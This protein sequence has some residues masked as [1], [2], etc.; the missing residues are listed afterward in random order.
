MSRE[1][2]RALRFYTEVLGLDHLHYGLW[3]PDEELTLANM[4][5]A[6]LRYED[7]LIGKLPAGA[8]S[9][10]DVGCG[11][12]AMTRRMLA[13]GLEVEGLSPDETQKDTFTR[14]LSVPFH[15]SRFEDFD[16]NRRYD[17]LVMSESCQYIPMEPLMEKVKARLN[18]GGHLVICDYFVL[19]NAQGIMAKSGH[20]YDRFKTLAERSGLQLVE[21]VDVTEGAARTLDLA[22][23]MAKRGLL[24]GDILTEKVRLKHPFITRVVFRLFR[25]KW[26]KINAERILIDSSAFKANKKYVYLKYRYAG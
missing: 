20:N 4:K 8:R 25:K 1:N 9:V 2:D 17:C 6:Q 23:D 3:K 7:F 26:N 14:T 22:A 19:D 18:P 12:S 5:V 16:S 15:H 24:A 13:L 21:E 11:T 10:L